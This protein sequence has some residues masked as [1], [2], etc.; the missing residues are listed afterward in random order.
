MKHPS[1]GY[2][3]VCLCVC[4]FCV[5]FVCV[6]L[7]CLL[8]L[9]WLPHFPSVPPFPS[10]PLPGCS[11]YLVGLSSW[12]WG[13]AVSFL[14]SFF[15]SSQLFSWRKTIRSLPLPSLPI[16]REPTRPIFLKIV[17]YMHVVGAFALS[18]LHINEKFVGPGRLVKLRAAA[19]GHVALAH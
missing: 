15:F 10:R 12:G 1:G 7:L 11:A 13:G 9:A 6:C 17:M 19:K 3:C 8:S 18:L 16:S 14:L 5:V 4:V 2:V